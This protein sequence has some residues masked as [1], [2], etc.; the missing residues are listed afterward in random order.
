MWLLITF[1]YQDSLHKTTTSRRLG[2]YWFAILIT[3]LTGKKVTDPTSG[4]FVANRRAIKFLS[5]YY[6]QITGSWGAF[7]DAQSQVKSGGVAGENV[8]A[9]GRKILD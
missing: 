2:I 8:S 3:L 4:M 9:D 1:F 6:P 5:R 7:T